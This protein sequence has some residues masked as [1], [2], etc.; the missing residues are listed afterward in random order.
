MDRFIT[1]DFWR[2]TRDDEWG[3]FHSDYE[4]KESRFGGYWSVNVGWFFGDLKIY[5][6]GNKSREKKLCSIP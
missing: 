5:S 1:T 6:F 3:G 2:A 4:A